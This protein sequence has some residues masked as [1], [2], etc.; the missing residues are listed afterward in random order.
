MILCTDAPTSVWKRDVSSSMAKIWDAFCK[1]KIVHSQGK[2]KFAD[3]TISWPGDTVELYERNAYTRITEDILNHNYQCVYITGTSGI[4]KSL[5]LLYLMYKLVLTSPLPS[6]I[7]IHY[8]TREGGNFLLLPN[9]FVLRT[10]M[11]S[12]V[13]DEHVPKFVLIDSV[14]V[15]TVDPQYGPH[16]LVASNS[17]HFKEFQKRVDEYRRR[18]KTIRMENWSKDELQCISAY[19]LDILTLR[20]DIFGGS[21]RNVFMLERDVPVSRNNSYS[22]IFDDLINMFF[23]DRMRTVSL[24][25]WEDA[26]ASIK[27]TIVNQLNMIDDVL[28]GK[29]AFISMFYHTFEETGQSWA[30]TFL[31]CLAGKL[32]D[33]KVLTIGNKVRQIVGDSG[34]MGV[35]FESL[36]HE[37]LLKSSCTYTA[38]SIIKGQRPKN[39]IFTIPKKVEIF[40]G[41]TDITSLSNPSY[42]LPIT[43]NFSCVD[44][45]M[46][47][48]TLLQYTISLIHPG[49][50][51]KVDAIRAQ[52]LDT[53][54]KNHA[55]IFVVPVDNFNA[56]AVQEGYGD[57]K[58]YK[59]T[60]Q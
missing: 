37:T 33:S 57:I 49:I 39:R 11:T 42:G 51:E 23:R 17:R 19:P 27:Y 45:V 26:L 52:L 29:Q 34:S 5:Y 54:L 24:K 36:V 12:P 47:P 28:D 9:G 30:T 40:R 48:N 15:Q 10:E 1:N 55:L 35:A 60:Y 6:S 4:G 22:I 32:M 59:M 8:K 3:R 14:N 43:G 50:Q 16:I 13:F 25:E 38:T 21:A 31:K 56:F 18:G 44:G 41:I 7:S 58:Q 20:F 2:I 53:N 46:Q